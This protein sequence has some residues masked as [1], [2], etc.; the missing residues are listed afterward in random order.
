M[1]E[2][3]KDGWRGV[4][5]WMFLLVPAHPGRPG[6]TAVKRL[7][8]CVLQKKHDEPVHVVMVAIRYDTQEEDDTYADAFE[9]FCAEKVWRWSFILSV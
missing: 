7:C 1:E 8:V 5:G 3:D 6:Q 4:S 2:A 9:Q